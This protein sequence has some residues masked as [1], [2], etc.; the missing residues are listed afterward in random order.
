MALADEVGEV[1]SE[2][3]VSEA[4]EIP[5]ASEARPLGEDGESQDFSFRKCRWM[6]YSPQRGTRVVPLPPLVDH[7]LEENE[8]G[9]E[10][11]VPPFGP[12]CGGGGGEMRVRPD[13]LPRGAE[14]RRGLT[15]RFS[16]QP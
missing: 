10:V 16:A 11:H 4:P 3:R 5:L 15:P 9:F 2:V 6:P 14:T 8:E 7:H 12:G 1:G 13:M